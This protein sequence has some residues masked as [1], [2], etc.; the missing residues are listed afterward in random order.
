MAARGVASPPA[1]SAA[2]SAVDLRHQLEAVHHDAYTWARQ[3]CH[4][5]DGDPDD[6]LQSAYLKVLSGGAEW[7]GRSSFRS[8]LFGIIRLTALSQHRRTWLRRSLLRRG[9]FRL[10]RTSARPT[11]Q[12]VE[13]EEDA[14]RLRALVNRLPVRQREVI[15]LVFY[16]DLNLDE[17]AAAMRVAPGTARSHYARGK[18]RLRELFAANA[19]E[20][21][22]R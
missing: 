18:A 19:G 17:A 6:V 21:D 8:W 14:R 2:E 22:A 16:H 13:E 12:A 5:G 9:Q 10:E 7:G 15:Y 3:C 4:D 11:D 20:P 1:T